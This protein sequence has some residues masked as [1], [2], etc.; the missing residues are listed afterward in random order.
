[1]NSLILLFLTLSSVTLLASA[2]DNEIVCPGGRAKCPEGST[3]CLMEGG[4]Y[5]CCPA[6]HAT[7]CSDKLHCC[8]EGFNC[9]GQ[10]CV[11]K[12]GY[13]SLSAFSKFPSTP[14]RHKEAIDLTSLEAELE[15][16]LDEEES[17]E[18]EQID[19]PDELRPIACGKERTC[20]AKTTCCAVQRLRRVQHMCCPLSNGVCCESSC[21][22]QG[23]H[24]IEGGK[25]E[26]HA[27][28]RHDFYKR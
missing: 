15:D 9:D 12:T 23:Y 27:K 22:P 1:M 5:G 13:L 3:C 18:D 17:V 16:E 2:I 24:C 10:R 8:P 19:L 11:H 7:C 21:C 14:I 28:S 6:A 25:C 20:P 4:D 26:K